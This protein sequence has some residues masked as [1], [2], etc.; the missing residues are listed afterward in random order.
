MG[1]IFR[2]QALSF[3]I[4]VICMGLIL[5]DNQY[6]HLLEHFFGVAHK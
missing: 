2:T 4:A 1:I 5:I 6:F 3:I